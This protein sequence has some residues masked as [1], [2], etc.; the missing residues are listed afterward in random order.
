VE[1]YVGVDVYSSV[2]MVSAI[3]ASERF[4]LWRIYPPY[5]LHVRLDTRRISVFI[6]VYDFKVHG[7][8]RLTRE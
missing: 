5:W 3:I 7:Y 4:T 1:A 8:Q 2:S 6:Q